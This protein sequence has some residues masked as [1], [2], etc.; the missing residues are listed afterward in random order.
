MGELKHIAI[1]RGFAPG[2]ISHKFK[3]R[4]G[5]WPNDPQVQASA[6]REPSLA[7]R[8]WIKSKAIAYAKATRANG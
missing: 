1:E 5:S 4:F 3:E 6:A 7:T 2:W 8:Y